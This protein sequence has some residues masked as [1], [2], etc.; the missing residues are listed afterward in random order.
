M[1]YDYNKYGS[2]TVHDFATSI[3]LVTLSR[4]ERIAVKPLMRYDYNKYGSCT[5]HDRNFLRQAFSW[6]LWVVLQLRWVYHAVCVSWL[7]RPTW[8]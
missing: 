5:V 8:V 2:C 6:W 3:F 4:A 7:P 1:R